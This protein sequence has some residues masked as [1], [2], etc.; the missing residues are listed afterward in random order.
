[1]PDDLR[2]AIDLASPGELIGPLEIERL[3][4]LVRVEKFLPASLDEPT[5]QQLMDELFEQWLEEKVQQTDVQLH[6]KF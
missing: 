1:M 5:K 2:A 6:V 3:W 4:Y